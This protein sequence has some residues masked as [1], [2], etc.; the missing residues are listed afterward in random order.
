MQHSANHDSVCI[1]DNLHEGEHQIVGGSD[2][3]EMENIKS[4]DHVVRVDKRK[5]EAMKTALLAVIP[6]TEPG[7]TVAELK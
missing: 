7:L 5:Y 1:L 6:K 2:K 3:V 4:P